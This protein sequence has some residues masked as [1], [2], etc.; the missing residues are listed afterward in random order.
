[1]K[2][3]HAEAFIQEAAELLETLE[4]SLLELE[5][6]MDDEELIQKIFRSLHTIKG[7]GGMFGYDDVASFVHSIETVFDNIRNHELNVNDDII[8]LT[9]KARDIIK[10]MINKEAVDE[11]LTSGILNGFRRYTTGT[12]EEPKSNKERNI[13]SD[14]TGDKSVYHILFVPDENLLLQGTNPIGLL[15]EFNDLGECFVIPDAKLVPDLSE[16]DPEKLYTSWNIFL[17]TSKGIDSI[18]DI[19]IFVDDNCRIEIKEIDKGDLSEDINLYLE[20]FKKS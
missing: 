13:E 10:L 7:S 9:L 8:D 18:K 16:Y 19:F 2:D 3:R 5:S 14:N 4:S 17:S 1:M 15:K 6:K 20:Y 12:E 11:N